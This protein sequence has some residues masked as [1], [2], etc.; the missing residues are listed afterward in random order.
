M[1]PRDTPYA[2]E[3]ARA[4]IPVGDGSEARIERLYL[5][6]TDQVEIRFSWWKSGRMTPRPL[7]LSE[8][9]L[10]ALIREAIA[11]QVFS[12]EFVAE[13]RA[14]LDEGSGDGWVR[15]LRQVATDCGVGLSDAAVS[16]EGIYD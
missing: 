13:L 1:A 10:L 2:R 16:S 5:K 15:R 9:M 6:G 8:N 7:D 3:I 11:Q 12:P 4:S 14:A